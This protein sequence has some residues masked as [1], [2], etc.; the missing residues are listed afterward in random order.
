MKRVLIVE[1]QA[2]IRKLIRMTLE[3]EPYE[4]HEA[5]NGTDGLRLATEVQPDLIL[6]DVMMPGM[7]GHEVCERLKASDATRHIPVI[8]VT[9]LSDETDETRDFALGAVDYITKPFSN[10]VVRAR[11]QTQL[12]LVRAEVL[13][14]TRQQ[15][16]QCLGAAAEFKDNETGL[17]VVR[18]SHYSRLIGQ[19]LREVA[20]HG[21]GRLGTCLR[22]DL[23]CRGLGLT[24]G[25]G[26]AVLCHHARKISF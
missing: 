6:L 10:P 24:G 23:R 18:M 26:L 5:A 12:S 11:I 15:V 13:L 9:A 2:D 21:V 19:A 22:L 3:F 20:R 16:V 1:D 14:A 8:F 25:F 17:H 4:I 7:T